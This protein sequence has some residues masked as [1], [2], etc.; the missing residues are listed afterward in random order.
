MRNSKKNDFKHNI[1]SS[2]ILNYYI[3][4]YRLTDRLRSEFKFFFIRSQH[5]NKT[6]EIEYQM[7]QIKNTY[8]TH[9]KTI[10]LQFIS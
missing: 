5:K 6:N 3:K 4:Y 9:F 8:V 10:F 7:H 2:N 1:I